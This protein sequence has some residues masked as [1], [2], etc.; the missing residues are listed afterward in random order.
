MT[1]SE[2]SCGMWGHL[3]ASSLMY[4]R[5]TSRDPMNAGLDV[6]SDLLQNDVEQEMTNPSWKFS[7]PHVLVA[8]IVAFLFGYHLGVVN[9]PLESISVDLGFSGDML[10]EG[11]VV[12]TCL[13]AAFAGSLVSGWIADGV[14]RRRAF[15]LCSLPMIIGASLCSHM[16]KIYTFGTN[17]TWY[18][19]SFILVLLMTKTSFTG[20]RH[21]MA[22]TEAERSVNKV[23]TE[24]T[25]NQGGDSSNFSFQLT[26]HKLNGKNY[27]E[28]AQF[29]CLAIDG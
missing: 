12:S 13:A 23:P 19:S 8:T 1:D 17:L 22:F 26:F 15:Q 9:E 10:A 20:L 16:N 7:C 29:V 21:P 2:L 24:T 11:L 5:M 18:Q 28:W 4:K 14:G 6:D 27:L 25:M 3:R